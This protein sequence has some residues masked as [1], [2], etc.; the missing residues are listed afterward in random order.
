MTVGEWSK[1]SVDYGRKLLDSGMEGAHE[2]E[3]AFLEGEPLAP[4]LGEA[5]R[6]AITPTAVGVCL[7]ILGSRSGRGRSAGKTL[8]FAVFGGAVGFAI[9]LGWQSRRLAVSVASGA[10]KNIEKTRD[11]HWLERNPIDYA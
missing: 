11:E 10:M 5:A 3:E 4:F 9:G 1:T 2:G 7:G 8:A 6:K